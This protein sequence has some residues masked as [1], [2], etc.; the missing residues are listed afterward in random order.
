MS[1][2][3]VSASPSQRKITVES[4][5]DLV[6]CVPATL[7]NG[8]WHVLNFP[9]RHTCKAGVMAHRLRTMAAFPEF[10]SSIPSNLMMTHNHL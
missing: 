7:Q 2:F 10:V 1:Q 3:T 9:L 6:I 5:C 8:R 4:H